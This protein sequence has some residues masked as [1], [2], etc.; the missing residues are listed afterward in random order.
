MPAYF[1]LFESA[2]DGT[3]DAGFTVVLVEVFVSVFV[4]VVLPEDVLSFDDVVLFAGAS[5]FF[6]AC[7]PSPTVLPA[8]ANIKPATTDCKTNR[9]PLRI[10]FLGKEM[11]S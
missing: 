9:R 7:A 3:F 6:C 11:T 10:D 4:L 2:F 1:A 8:T 5:C